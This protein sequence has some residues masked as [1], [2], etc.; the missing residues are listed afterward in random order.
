MEDNIKSRIS[1]MLNYVPDELRIIEH[2]MTLEAMLS[3]Y[4]MSRRLKK[5][6]EETI[7]L[8]KARSWETLIPNRAVKELLVQLAA[9]GSVECFRMLEGIAPK[10][11]KDIKPFGYVALNQAR[12]LLE[13]SLMDGPVG[14]IVSGLGGKG[15]KIRFYFAVTTKRP[16]TDGMKRYVRAVYQDVCKETDSEMEEIEFSEQYLLI[17]MLGSFDYSISDIIERGIQECDFLDNRFY[18]TNISKP[19]V[20]DIQHWMEETEDDEIDI[21]ED[22]ED[23]DF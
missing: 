19:S 6:E 3:F 15:N 23:F 1:E 20:E 17:K 16:F 21:E 14:F 12:M 7:V 11:P 10:L 5:Q 2:E 4:N 9:F 8:E 22:I 18:V 13:T